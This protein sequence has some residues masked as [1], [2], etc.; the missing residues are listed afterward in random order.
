VN[1]GTILPKEFKIY[2]LDLLIVEEEG[3]FCRA[4]HNAEL[5]SNSS[6]SADSNLHLKQ[7]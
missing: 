4:G 7:I 2:A 6:I 5:A 1:S 3:L